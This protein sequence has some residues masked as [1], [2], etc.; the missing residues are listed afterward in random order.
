MK[1]VFIALKVFPE[2]DLLRMISSLK[3]LLGSENIKWVDPANIHLT[4]AFLGDTEEKRIKILTDILREKCTGF[5]EFEFVL[6]GTDIFKNF[7]DPRI[8]WIGIMYSEKLMMLNNIVTDSLRENG[9]IVEEREFRPHLT[10]G[11]IKSIRDTENLKSALERYRD[12]QIQSVHVSEVI[13]FESILS[14]TGPIYKS[15]GNFP[16]S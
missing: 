6:A 11:R 12:K 16:L 14:Q 3:A 7:R 2:G 5:H 13:L 9:F 4:L 10:L 1:R 15:L 8:I